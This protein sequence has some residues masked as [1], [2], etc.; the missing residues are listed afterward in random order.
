MAESTKSGGSRQWLTGVFRINPEYF[1]KCRFVTAE[2][3]FQCAFFCPPRTGGNPTR[4]MIVELQDI[5]IATK[6]ESGKVRIS[7]TT[8]RFFKR[9]MRPVAEEGII[10][11][12]E[13]NEAISQLTSLAEHGI[14]KPAVIPKLLDQQEV[15]E[16]LGIS[17]SNFKKL[18]AEGAFPFKRKMVGSAVRYRNTDVIDYIISSEI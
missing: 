12:P 5:V 15:A 14:P 8:V 7:M 4:Q 18:E 1:P 13:Y 11:L 10:S 9:I 17:H 6:S 16:M 3:Q 2:M